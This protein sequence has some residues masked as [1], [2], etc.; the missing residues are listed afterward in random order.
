MQK[1]GTRG[2]HGSSISERNHSSIL[3][4]LNDGVESGNLYCEK[5]QTLV[6]DLFQR[7]DK[8]VIKWNQQIYNESNDLLLLRADINK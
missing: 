3:V 4:Y 5:P 2:K 1:R 7:Q 6:K 8:H